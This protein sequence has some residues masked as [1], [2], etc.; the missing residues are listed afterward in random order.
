MHQLPDPDSLHEALL[1]AIIRMHALSRPVAGLP[2]GKRMEGLKLQQ[3][4][5]ATDTEATLL[6][7]VLDGWSSGD[8]STGMHLR[9]LNATISLLSLPASSLIPI[10][11]LSPAHGTLHVVVDPAISVPADLSIPPINLGPQPP[12]PLESPTVFNNIH[13]GGVDPNTPEGSA[14]SEVHSATKML[15]KDRASTATKI[16]C[17]NGTPPPLCRYS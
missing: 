12:K 15:R 17:S 11:G 1:A 6:S 9:L 13:L 3:W 10:T 8:R 16:L 7:P 5:T 14:I 4:K 2:P